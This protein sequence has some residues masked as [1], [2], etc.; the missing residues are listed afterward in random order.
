MFEKSKQKT[1][2]GDTA[3][4]IEAL[5]GIDRRENPYR[6]VLA[7]E[8]RVL[9]NAREQGMN[10]HEAALSLVGVGFFCG[11]AKG[12]PELA[13]EMFSVMMTT[14]REQFNAG[15]IRE[16]FWSQ[17]TRHIDRCV[18]EMNDLESRSNRR[19]Q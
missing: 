17:F 8:H 13:R 15:Q 5:Y 14:A 2:N 11:L 1:W 10:P 12:R 3:R 7:A 6:P 4:L 16:D 18:R 19:E 9:D